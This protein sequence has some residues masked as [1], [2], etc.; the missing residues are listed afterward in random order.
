MRGSVG[1][2]SVW[3]CASASVLRVL[4]LG[5][6]QTRSPRLRES[7]PFGKKKKTCAGLRHH[8]GAPA[9]AG[10]R[11]G[12][13]KRRFLL[14]RLRTSFFFTQL[15]R[16]LPMAAPA[17]VVVWDFDFSLIPAVN[18]DTH[19]PE[20][21]HKDAAAFIKAGQAAGTQW[22]ALMDSVLGFLHAEGVPCEA[23]ERAAAELPSD[24]HIMAAI[25]ALHQRGARQ[26]IL[27]DAN[28]LYISRFLEAQ[29]SAHC[30]TAVY[31]NPA[32]VEGGRV[33]VAPFHRE[34]HGC[35][36]CPVNLC[37]GRVLEEA[38]AAEEAAGGGA[39]QR[40]A[41]IGDG[42]GDVCPCLKLREGD[43]IFARKGWALHKQ[44][45]ALQPAAEVRPWEG[46]QGL[47][48]A[49]LAALGTAPPTSCSPPD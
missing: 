18:S 7:P 31:T 29:H 10:R 35:P 48:G 40:W 14:T 38:R 46:G 5:D 42:G 30:F 21:L 36:R 1:P 41:Y 33:R 16:C 23:I 4:R 9:Q 2:H 45:G 12:G 26:Y 6:T 17:V 39:G 49:L 15:E 28:S 27:S 25:S 19:I 13:L 11:V 43:A 24:A 3:Q 8:D 32:A 44:L 34:P 22:T 20:R 37:K 47:A